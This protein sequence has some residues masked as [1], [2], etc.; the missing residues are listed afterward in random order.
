M[1]IFKRTILD[2]TISIKLI[3]NFNVMFSKNI[4]NYLN[5]N[6]CMKINYIENVFEFL[7]NDLNKIFDILMLL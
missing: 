7:L 5:F 4:E 3:Y 1:C 6:K 2:Y